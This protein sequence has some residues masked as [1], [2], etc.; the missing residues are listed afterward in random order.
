MAKATF[1]NPLEH[2]H[3]QRAEAA[4]IRAEIA[5]QERTPLGQKQLEIDRLQSRFDEQERE[6]GRLAMGAAKVIHAA[7]PHIPVE[8]AFNNMVTNRK[9]DG[10]TLEQ[11]LKLAASLSP[12]ELEKKFETDY[13]HDPSG[14]AH[15]HRLAGRALRIKRASERGPEL[16]GEVRKLKAQYPGRDVH[17]YYSVAASNLGIK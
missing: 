12:A 9:D 10:L 8:V 4:A 17:W 15:A 2:Y 16:K 1:D 3:K 5:R 7:S 11:V 6:R 14:L 13:A